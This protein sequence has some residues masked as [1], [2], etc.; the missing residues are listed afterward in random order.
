MH[1][2][3]YGKDKFL[4]LANNQKQNNLNLV[5]HISKMEYLKNVLCLW[6]ISNQQM[7]YII[8]EKGFAKTLPQKNK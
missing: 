4:F 1:Q 6:C 7:V 2:I 8:Y 5:N 3:L